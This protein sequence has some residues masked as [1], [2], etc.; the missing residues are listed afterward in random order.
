MSGECW[1][2]RLIGDLPNFYLYAS[3]NPSEGALAKRRAAAT[4]ISYLTP[5]IAKAGLYK[6]LADLKASLDTWR[7]MAP[8]ANDVERADALALIQAQA[9]AVDVAE[10]EP[11]LG[12]NA[13]ARV[14]ALNESVLELE[15]SLIPHGL[16]VVGAPAPAAERAELLDAA[17]ITD[18]AQRAS[19]D[20]LLA[21]DHETPAIIHALDGGYI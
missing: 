17:G 3:N 8:N 10:A 1:P 21:T 12:G 14:T 11:A 13:A 9:A 6:G 18:P 15:Y 5:S 7:S 4:L 20:A 2:D 16:H 19:L